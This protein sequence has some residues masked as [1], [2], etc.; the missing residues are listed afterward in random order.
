MKFESTSELSIIIPS[1][2]E[3]ENIE[4]MILRLQDTLAGI[5]WEAIYVDDDSPDGTADCIREFAKKDS[6]VRVLQRIGRR[7]LSSAVVEGI[8]SSSAPFI[9]VIDAD[10]QH[11]ESLLPSMLQEL[12][13]D[14][15]LGVLI[16]SRYVEGGGT[17]DWNADRVFIS[18]FASKISRVV[19]KADIADPMSGFFMMRRTVF[20]DV[21]R[22]L[23]GQGFKILLDIFASASTPIKFKELPYEFRLRQHGESKLDSAIVW[24]YGM[25]ILD[26]LFGHI[27]PARFIIFSGVGLLGLGLYLILLGISYQLMEIPFYTAVVFATIITI[28]FN[29]LLHNLFTYRDMRLK[30][31][32]ILWGLLIFGAISV[33]G[34]IGNVGVAQFVLSQGQLWWVAGIAGA[35]VGVVWNYAA[36][37]LF[38]WR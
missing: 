35:L 26:K 3:R 7:G 28:I 22:N 12:R 23:S 30:G 37:S 2:N 8:L 10:M 38:T 24:E 14:E 18:Q 1:F 32:K 5:N 4:P 15:Q 9:A 11:D 19:T 27:V 29:F 17:G 6:R 25:L 20:N 36:S 16:G 31:I 34:I 21:V 13:S 33:V